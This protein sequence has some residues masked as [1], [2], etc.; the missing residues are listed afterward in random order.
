M[1]ARGAARGAMEAFPGGQAGSVQYKMRNGRRSVMA[2][3]IQHRRKE[4]P[5]VTPLKDVNAVIEKGEIV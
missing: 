3:E 5:N 2:I 1:P 4:Y